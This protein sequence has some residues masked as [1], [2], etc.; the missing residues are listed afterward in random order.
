MNSIVRSPVQIVATSG[1]AGTVG[2]FGAELVGD[3]PGHGKPNQEPNPIRFMNYVEDPD[4]DVEK[5]V[6]RCGAAE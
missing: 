2:G 6:G 5:K 4:I 1:H 3:E